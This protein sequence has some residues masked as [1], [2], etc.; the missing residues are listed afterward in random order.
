MQIDS[1]ES[2]IKELRSSGLLTPE[3]L[4]VVV[5]DLDSHRGDFQSLLRL[6]VNKKRLTVYQLRKVIHGKTSELFLGP[7]I[8]S[9]RLGE[10]G[11]GKVYRATQVRLGRE[12]ALKV[13]RTS[14]LNN[15]LVRK[16]Y[17]REVE[18]A[19]AL[20]H[21]NIVGVFDAG[22]VEGRYYLAM[23]FVDGIDLS[24]LVREFSLLE[25]TEVC[26]YV[27][28]ASLGL[29]YAHEQGLVHRD[30]KPSNI[31]VAGERHLP[32]ASERATVKILDMGLVRSVGFDEDG[33]GGG[34]LTR[35]GTVVGTPDYMAPEQ[36]KNSSTV[37]HRADLYSLGCTMYFLL[38]GQPPF[39]T[40]TPIEKLLKHQ[41]DAPTPIQALRP[42]VPTAVAELISRLIVKDP[43]QRIQTAVELA[44]LIAPLALYPAGTHPVSI[45][46]RHGQPAAA[47][48]E[49]FPPSSRSTLPPIPITNSTAQ[50]EQTEQ[51]AI[52]LAEAVAPSD[53][54]PSPK[55]PQSKLH[56]VVNDGSPFSSLSD[57]VSEPPKSIETGEQAKTDAPPAWK[58]IVWVVV[59]MVLLV[60]GWMLLVALLRPWTPLCRSS[61]ARM[62]R[63]LKR[64]RR[65]H[66]A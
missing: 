52:P 44:E 60:V 20:N 40:G 58:T 45:H 61:L 5:R 53:Q 9:D 59:L 66:K 25:V 4:L 27:R 18:T 36:A 22:E 57:P 35:A 48:A 65:P 26:E 56:A 39:P 32:Q 21:P 17:N 7:Y 42:N 38:S 64:Q 33:G 37:D 31:V 43:A 63:V 13:V 24:R 3:Q 47:T 54:T 10:G 15:P 28:Q 50:L 29:H 30:I 55:E 2:L 8:I 14:L 23:E 11:M 46:S 49:T 62:A 1:A 41:L 34:D 6:L 19:S 16:R 12:V 51:E